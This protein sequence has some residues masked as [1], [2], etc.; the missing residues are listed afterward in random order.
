MTLFT[1]TPHQYMGGEVAFRM[2][3]EARISETTSE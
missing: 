2:L 1:F 3:M